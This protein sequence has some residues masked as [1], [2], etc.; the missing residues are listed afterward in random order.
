MSRGRGS[1]L[2]FLMILS[3]FRYREDT[4]EILGVTGLILL[5]W[6]G[7]QRVTDFREPLLSVALQPTNA[8]PCSSKRGGG[9][10]SLPDHPLLGLLINQG[11]D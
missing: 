10:A 7:A 2:G 8:E 4:T 11:H 3:V 9:V 6:N 1:V 5:L